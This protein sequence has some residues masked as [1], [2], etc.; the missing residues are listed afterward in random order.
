MRSIVI[1]D[2]GFGDAGK[3]L[4][5]DYLVRRTGAKVVVRYNGGAQAGHNV[6]TPDGR[7]HTFSQFGA[8]SF[9]AGV[10]TFLSRDVVVHP[11]ALLHE[12]ASLRATGV[13]DGF[14]RLRIS[15]DAVVITP[16]HQTLNRLREISRGAARHGSCGAGVGE[17]VAHDRARAEEA[18]RMRDLMDVAALRRKLQRIR[19]YTWA[20][21]GALDDSVR[22]SAEAKL[23]DRDDVQQEW[24]DRARCVA[25]LAADERAWIPDAGDENAT[26]VFEGAQ[27]VLLDEWHGFHPYTTWSTCTSAPALRLLSELAPHA[28]VC[29]I[30][31]LRAYAVRHG[32]GPL[33]TETDLPDTPREHNTCNAWQGLVRRGWFD[34]VLA[35]YAVEA[36]GAIDTVAVTHLDWLPRIANWTY[37]ERY[38]PDIPLRPLPLR[39]VDEQEMLTS[40]LRSVRPVLKHC[41][42]N[43][44]EVLPIIEELVG[45]PVTIGSRGP[46]AGDVFS[47]RAAGEQDTRYDA[48]LTG[49]NRGGAL[50]R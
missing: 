44:E 45:K 41:A 20:E 50:W 1:V 31:V 15:A 11:T 35:R 46:S 49:K 17:A 42:A 27:G 9:I 6:V 22:S 19:D 13:T 23:F 34:G 7:H 29:T 36:D 37:C 3:G 33:P 10:R 43:E 5:T 32:A 38:V 21:A 24:I 30:G 14:E 12:E 18:I 48:V 26:V 47:R 28:T 2:L 16:Y 25:T 8:G 39:S 4:L 40:R